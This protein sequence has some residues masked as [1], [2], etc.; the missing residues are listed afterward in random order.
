MKRK[1]FFLVFFVSNFIFAQNNGIAYQA[2]I[3]KQDNKNLPGVKNTLL[4]LD[5]SNVCLQ[6]TIITGNGATV[7]YREQ[8]STKTDQF[9]LVNVVIGSG[10]KVGGISTSLFNI[11]WTTINIELVV[12]LDYGGQCSNF[13]EISR[14]KFTA[15][16]FALNALTT[17][18]ISGIVPI[19]NGGTGADTAIKARDNLGLGNVDNTSDINKPISTQTLQAL[20]LKEDL[21][22]KSTDFALDQNSNIKYPTVKSVRDYVDL[23]SKIYETVF[24]ATRNMFQFKTPRPFTDVSKIQVFRNGIRI[25]LSAVDSSNIQL[26][27][28]VVCDDND[29]IRIVQSD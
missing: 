2:V 12:E 8:L 26:E 7:E 27:N 17:N 9:G 20:N 19:V 15:V 10:T 29:E 28:G 21:I 18:S 1:I 14:Q 3:Y 25:G 13:V 16:P 23:R 22:N 11:D 24:V 4:P 5:N 6:F